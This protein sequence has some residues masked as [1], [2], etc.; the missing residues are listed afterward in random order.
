M[1]PRRPEQGRERR[2]AAVRPIVAG[3]RYGVSIC[4]DVGHLIRYELDIAELFNRYHLRISI[5]HLHGVENNQDHLSLDRLPKG[6]IAPILRILKQ[7]GGTVSVEVFS[8][9]DLSASLQ[10]LEDC[11]NKFKST[12][13]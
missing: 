4:L 7:F 10:F 8:Y 9:N 6:D 12:E 2:L 3:D 1:D 5:I 11:W 13:I